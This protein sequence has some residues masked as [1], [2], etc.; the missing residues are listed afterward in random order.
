MLVYKYIVKEM[1]DLFDK[2]SFITDRYIMIN[3]DGSVS[4]EEK[5]ILW[6]IIRYYFG[7]IQ[8]V[9]GINL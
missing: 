6:Y 5:E 4:R 7:M 3:F 9:W 2:M 1:E 8:M